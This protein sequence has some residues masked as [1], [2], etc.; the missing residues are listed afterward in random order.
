VHSQV[1]VRKMVWLNEQQQHLVIERLK[2][3]ARRMETE[4]PGAA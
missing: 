1:G 4:T 2:M 3:W